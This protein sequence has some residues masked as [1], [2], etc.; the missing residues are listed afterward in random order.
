MDIWAFNLRHLRAI[1]AIAQLGT[2]NAAAQAVNLTQ[3]AI[4]QA[5]AR[6]EAMLGAPLFMRQHHGMTPTGAARLLVPRIEAAL[7]HVASNRVTMAGLRAFLALAEAG[8]YTAAAQQVGLAAPSLHRAVGELALA[9]RRVLVERHGKAV[10]LTEAG[11]RLERGFRLA[12]VE[13]E[14][15]LG[16]LNALKGIET[17]RIVVGAM[18]L[19]RAKV[20]P[21]AVTRL[22]ARHPRVRVVIIEGSR[23]ELL[24]PLRNGTIDLMVGALREPLHEEDLAQTPLFEDQPCV[25][26]RAGHPLAGSVA[27]GGA[28]LADL[29]AYPW[30]ISGPGTPLRQSWQRMFADGG[31]ALP[32]VPLESGSVMVIR[33]VLIGSDYLTLLSPDQVLVELEAGWLTVVARPAGLGRKLGITTRASW[34]PTAVQADFLADLATADGNTA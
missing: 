9:L 7:A 20:V 33:Q 2:M 28:S 31:V 1:A 11:R 8:S 22:L 3:P 10:I 17:R 27:H 5:L 4:T 26:A 15:G 23:A 30:V 21:A 6:T 16:E 24:E 25:I 34:R 29:A 32:P 13:L 18:P 12:K 14:A 19:S